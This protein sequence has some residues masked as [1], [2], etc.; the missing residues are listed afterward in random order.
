[1][2]VLGHQNCQSTL[3]YTHLSKFEGDEFH[4]AVAKTIEEAG[5]LV[6]T[7]FEFVCDFNGEKLFRKRKY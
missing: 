6:D 7:G 3:I 1:M 5:K 4:H 2:R